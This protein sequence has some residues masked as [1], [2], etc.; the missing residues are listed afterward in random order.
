MST[1]GF[2]HAYSKEYTP[3]Q[4]FYA[5]VYEEWPGHDKDMDPNDM[6]QLYDILSGLTEREGEIIKMRCGLGC[7]P[8]TCR[9]IG[10]RIGVNTERARQLLLHAFRKLRRFMISGNGV[11]FLFATRN[12]L[13]AQIVEQRERI[14]LLEQ[15]LNDSNLR[16]SLA[17]KALP[18]EVVKDNPDITNATIYPDTI[19]IEELDFSVRTYNCLKRSGKNTLADLM[20]LSRA[21]LRRIRNL[22]YRGAIEV[23]ENLSRY[24][25]SLRPNDE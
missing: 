5:M 20:Q 6:S 4:N 25:L 3:T 13:K 15:W 24:G 23:E 12:E 17:I 8:M 16:L 19:T 11:K 2:V 14:K 9:E 21:Y 22:G 18:S 10:E 1:Y 7:N